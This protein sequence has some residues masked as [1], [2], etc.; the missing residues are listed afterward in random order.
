M[1]LL[2]ILPLNKKPQRP[3]LKICTKCGGKGQV[4]YLDQYQRKTYGEWKHASP[5]C[6]WHAKESYTG[7]SQLATLVGFEECSRPK[8]HAPGV[9]GRKPSALTASTCQR[10]LWCSCTSCSMGVAILALAVPLHACLQP[11]ATTAPME[12]HPMHLG[13]LSS[14]YAR[15]SQCHTAG[16]LDSRPNTSSMQWSRRTCG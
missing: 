1:P 8:Q 6:Q 16:H 9:L 4:S 10:T 7:S 13:C 12:V 15:R 14:V 3:Y 11:R 5:F 2:S